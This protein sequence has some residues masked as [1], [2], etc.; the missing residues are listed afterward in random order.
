MCIRLTGD[1]MNNE[2]LICGG[3]G[4]VL[5][6][7]GTATQL[8]EILRTIS[9]ILTILGAIISFIVVPLLNWYKSA[10]KD[11]KIDVDELEE[12]ARIL[13]EGVKKT[14]QSIKDSQ[15]D[16]ADEREEIKKE[17]GDKHG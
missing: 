4:A 6:I 2:T 15:C 12:A 5:G 13:D 17:K 7:V 8:N 1:N 16:D 11:G 10:K 14:N 9:L 3:V